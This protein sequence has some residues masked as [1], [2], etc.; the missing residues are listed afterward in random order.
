MG[1]LTERLLKATHEENCC[2]EECCCEEHEHN[3]KEE[4]LSE[5][6]IERIINERYSEKDEKTKKFIRRG[7]RKFGDRFDYSKTVYKNA[8][9][10]VVIICKIHHLEFEQKSMAHIR[11]DSMNN[12]CPHCVHE[13][14][15]MPYEEFQE[16]ASIV[17]NNKYTYIR[18]T[19][20]GCKKKLSIIC[21]I[22]GIF[23]QNG[24]VHLSGSGCPECAREASK[25]LNALSQE[26]AI[27]RL[28]DIYKGNEYSFDKSVYSG[29]GKS[30][31]ATCN[32]CNTTFSVVYKNLLNPDRCHC[33]NCLSLEKKLS[34]EEFV[35]ESEKVHGKGEYIYD[36][37]DYV[38]YTTPVKIYDPILN[39]F[40]YQSPV[41][42]LSGGGNPNRLRK[43]IGEERVVKWLSEN[44][45]KYTPQVKIPELGKRGYIIDFKI[46]LSENSDDYIFLEY[47]GKQHYQF[48]D[49]FHKSQEDFLHQLERDKEVSN[50]CSEKN[51]KLITVPYTLR[52]LSSISD[53]LTKTIIEGID[54]HTLI[55]YDVL[56][57]VEDNNST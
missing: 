6:E 19:Y 20:N 9:T 31:L 10:K 39:E 11:T 12:P 1:K 55:D 48:V 43:S 57:V 33:P 53:F 52:T 29:F 38:N 4:N 17:H 25:E 23:E 51:I 21:P 45:I 7:L 26:E 18:E 54:P 40:F 56:Y 42:H 2:C 47:N 50:Y 32:V 24:S 15:M 13:F 30:I 44:N 8:R 28:K 16:R 46:Y 22:H 14:L 5:E 36:Y 49:I 35:T 34:L 3:H 41:V 37:V 27:N